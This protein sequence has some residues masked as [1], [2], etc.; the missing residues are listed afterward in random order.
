MTLTLT[1]IIQETGKK[2][3]DEKTVFYDSIVAFIIILIFIAPS[4]RLLELSV[5][6]SQFWFTGMALALPLLLLVLKKLNL[7]KWMIKLL[8]GGEKNEPVL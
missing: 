5:V 8:Y 3:W 4:Q 7:L 6:E 2:L 1:T